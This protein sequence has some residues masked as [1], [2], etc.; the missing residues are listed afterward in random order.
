M[1]IELLW[2]LV[3]LVVFAGIAYGIMAIV[4]WMNV[5]E[6]LK[7]PV[8]VIVGLILIIVLIGMLVGGVPGPHKFSW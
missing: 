3:M 8:R 6:K 5:P 2:L 7:M 4:D 1:V